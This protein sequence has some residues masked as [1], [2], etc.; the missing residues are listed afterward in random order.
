M[1]GKRAVWLPFHLLNWAPQVDGFTLQMASFGA[2]AAAAYLLF[3]V[4]AMGLEFL[5]GRGAARGA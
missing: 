3:V 2:R 4:A 1:A 5:T